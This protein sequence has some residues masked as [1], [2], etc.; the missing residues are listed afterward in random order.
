MKTM[1]LLA[2]AVSLVSV[3]ACSSDDD[4]T[5]AAPSAAGAGGAEAG[6]GGS[7]A[8]SAGAAGADGGGAGTQAQAQ[9]QG[10]SAGSSAGAAGSSGSSSGLLEMVSFDSFC[11]GTLLEDLP[12]YYAAFYQE[13]F[14]REGDPGPIAPAGT[15]FWIGYGSFSSTL[16]GYF[17]LPDGQLALM[18]GE[19]FHVGLQLGKEFESTC[20]PAEIQTVDTLLLDTEVYPTNEPTGEPC[21]VPRGTNTQ[22]GFVFGSDF[23][24][25]LDRTV[26]SPKL[27]KLC[28]FTKGYDTSFYHLPL[29]LKK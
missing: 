8:G 12:L 4:A 10:G 28:G 19:D 15:V 11:T 9:A 29:V 21:I 20:L 25:T 14:Y 13:G 1:F 23:T 7:T 16:K 2:V 5:P 17:I 6:A 18:D 3:V 22:E 24:G 26:E 27:Q